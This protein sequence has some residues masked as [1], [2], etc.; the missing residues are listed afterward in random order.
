MDQS[1]R[2]NGSDFILLFCHLIYHF[3]QRHGNTLIHVL[4]WCEIWM[5][6]NHFLSRSRLHSYFLSSA[7]P[8]RLTHSLSHSHTQFHPEWLRILPLNWSLIN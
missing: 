4:V 5:E 3:T 6:T 8:L 7:L 1:Y 2:D